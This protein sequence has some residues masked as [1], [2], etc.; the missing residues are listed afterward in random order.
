MAKTDGVLWLMTARSGSKS[1]PHK[2][3]KPLGGLPLLAH[4]IISANAIARPEDIWISTDSAEYADIACSRG[5]S[6]PFLRPPDLASDTAK[7][8]DVV[9]H[10]MDWAESHGRS[11]SAVCV[12]EPTS[13]FIYARHLKEAADRLQ[14]DKD[15][16]NI[17]AVRQVRPS[18]VFVQ[19][20]TRYLDVLAENIRRSAITRRQDEQ[21]EVTPSGGFY[22][23]KWDSFRRNKSFYTDLTLPFLVPD[24]CALE[25]DEPVDWDWA[26]FMIDR[27]RVDMDAVH[28]RKL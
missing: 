7:S 3:I 17:V 2:N 12:L 11:Y 21:I 19:P 4:R 24:E 15:S 5:A 8:S 26:E 28:G 14:A 9:L 22:I 16:E 10:A 13:P 25:I 23:A 20:M 27:K 18:T 1:I 6:A